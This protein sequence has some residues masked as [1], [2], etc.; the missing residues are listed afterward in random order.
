M[1]RSLLRR[2][3]KDKGVSSVEYIIILVLVALTGIAVFKIFGG[4]IKTKMN[5]ANN[6]MQN[7]VNPQ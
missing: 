1:A 5:T 3:R 4:Q 7:D 6:T 2:A